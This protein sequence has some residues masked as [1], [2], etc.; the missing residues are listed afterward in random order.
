MTDAPEASSTE[1]SLPDRAVR[2]E[3]VEVD[4]PREDQHLAEAHRLKRVVAYVKDKPATTMEPQ[5][6]GSAV[7]MARLRANR[8]AQGLVQGFVPAGLLAAA[9]ID[10]GDWKPTLAA[11][12]V[13]RRALA[14]SGWRAKLIA[15]LLP[16]A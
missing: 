8:E 10:G 1:T 3:V 15:W 7:R 12:A 16:H 14:A 4:H 5:R 9:S 11:I 13:G 2:P 6:K